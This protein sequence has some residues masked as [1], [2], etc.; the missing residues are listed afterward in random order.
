MYKVAYKWC[1][2]QGDAE[3]IT[4]DCCIKLS[5]A[6]HTFNHKAKFSS[7]LYRMVINTAHDYRKKHNPVDAPIEQ[8]DTT[9]LQDQ[10][11]D[12]KKI[13]FQVRQLPDNL[14]DA[15]L[16]VYMEGFTHKE[17][18]EIMDCAEKTVSWYISE[19]KTHL[20]QHFEQV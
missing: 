17:A 2:H 3:D 1:G 11:T 14:R 9:P 8:P 19:A 20:K 18:G 12:V 16:L 5:R 4:Q 6:L 15:T 13:W 10:Q 7:W